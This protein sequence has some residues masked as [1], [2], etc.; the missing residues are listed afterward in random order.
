[1][2]N[3]TIYYDDIIREN[4]KTIKSWEWVTLEQNEDGYEL[5]I[6]ASDIDVGKYVIHSLVVLENKSSYIG[7]YTI[8]CYLNDESDLSEIN[9]EIYQIIDDEN[10]IIMVTKV[11]CTSPADCP[12][13][14]SCINYNCQF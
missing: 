14:T 9:N 11:F 8:G 1:M 13:G 10:T 2:T 12:K 5:I 4:Y 6:D 3:Y 7:M